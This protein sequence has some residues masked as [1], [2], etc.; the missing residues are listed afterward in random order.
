MNLLIA[1][2][3]LCMLVSAL[4]GG[5]VVQWFA[6]S[7][8]KQEMESIEDWRMKYSLLEEDR[9]YHKNKLLELKEQYSLSREAIV[10]YKAEICDLKERGNSISRQRDEFETKY[11][12]LMETYQEAVA[13]RDADHR[14]RKKEL[15]SAKL[16]VK[17]LLKRVSVLSSQKKE[18]SRSL[19]SAQDGQK[20]DGASPLR[21]VIN[22]RDKLT[23]EI[24][25]LHHERESYE[26][27]INSLAEDHQMLANKL[28]ELKQERDEYTD[29]LRTI[30]EAAD[31]LESA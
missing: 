25:V 21:L 24:E 20:N 17:K 31:R 15:E 3:I 6:R 29:R 16:K 8:A 11:V 5:V 28:A 19:K 23:Q 14:D 12:G 7:R 18:V 1:K 9:R 27:R 22:E 30:S 10:K 2:L 13:R 4:L 26:D